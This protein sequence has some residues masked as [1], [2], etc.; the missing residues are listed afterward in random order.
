MY[1]SF[2][3]FHQWELSHYF[4][5]PEQFLKPEAMAPYIPVHVIQLLHENQ[6]GILI[7]FNTAVQLASTTSPNHIH[8]P[9][10]FT[11]TVLKLLFFSPS[12]AQ[13]SY[14]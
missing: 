8:I 12:I 1:T 2:P 14:M 4:G 7:K 10:T 6:K 3:G 9:S 13:T 11:P 5:E